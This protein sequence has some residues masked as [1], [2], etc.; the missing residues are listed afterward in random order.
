[1]LDFLS[2]KKT[3]IG[4]ILGTVLAVLGALG[5]VDV[6]SSIFIVAAGGIT[7]FTGISVRLAIDKSGT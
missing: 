2:G 6:D 7:A 5:V 3:Y 4:V 1:M